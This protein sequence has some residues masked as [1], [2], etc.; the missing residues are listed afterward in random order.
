MFLIY[1]FSFLKNIVC[2]NEEDSVEIKKAEFINPR[3]IQEDFDKE[4]RFYNKIKDVLKSKNNV[5]LLKNKIDGYFSIIT[6][7][8]T[9]ESAFLFFLNIFQ[10]KTKPDILDI[11]WEIRK[12]CYFITEKIKGPLENILRIA[13]INEEVIKFFFIKKNRIRVRLYQKEEFVTKEDPRGELGC[14]E[15]YLFLM[16]NRLLYLIYLFNKHHT[17]LLQIYDKPDMTE[18]NLISFMALDLFINRCILHILDVMMLYISEEKY[19]NIV[20][21]IFCFNWSITEF[22]NRV[23]RVLFEHTRIAALSCLGK[24]D[25]PINNRTHKYFETVYLQW[26]DLS[27]NIPRKIITTSLTTFYNENEH[28]GTVLETKEMMAYKLK[29]DQKHSEGKEHGEGTSQ[30]CQAVDGSI[31]IPAEVNAEITAELSEND[32]PSAKKQ[33]Q[34]PIEDTEDSS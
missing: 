34:S 22:Y 6:N 26:N 19:I 16:K 25:R 12:L 28:L 23:I 31:T 27:K 9:D 13:E 3:V 11:A 18:D 32:E 15:Y 29:V 4:N 1:L 2:T 24:F 33:T 30:V 14:Y 17:L 8:F 21:P 10:K 20:A 5:K 7:S